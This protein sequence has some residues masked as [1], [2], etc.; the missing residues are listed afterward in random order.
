MSSTLEIPPR[1][2]LEL[3]QIHPD[4]LP[5]ERVNTLIVF[6]IALVVLLA[7]VAVLIAGSLVIERCLNARHPHRMVKPDIL[8]ESMPRAAYHQPWPITP[9]AEFWPEGDEEPPAISQAILVV[10]D[11]YLKEDALRRRG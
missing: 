5:E 8:S 7:F 6:I 11:E 10:R 4:S 9:I 2:D 3:A 1:I